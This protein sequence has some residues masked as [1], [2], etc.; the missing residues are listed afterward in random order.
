MELA[1]LGSGVVDGVGD[2]DRQAQVAGEVDRLG[3][4][5]VV[6]RTEMVRQLDG[7]AVRSDDAGQPLG[8]RPRAGP[9]ADEQPPTD[10]PAPPGS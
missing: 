4:E 6:V 10:L 7:E 9:V 8:R 1:I 3:D 5:P 2:D